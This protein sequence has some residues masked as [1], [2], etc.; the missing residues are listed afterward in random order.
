VQI[1]I[2]NQTYFPLTHEHMINLKVGTCTMINLKKTIIKDLPSP[3]SSCQSADAMGSRFYNEFIENNKSYTQK[4]CM[5]FCKQKKMI[6]NCGCYSYY[7]P[8][9]GDSKPCLD[10]NQISCSH[11]YMRVKTVNTG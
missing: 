5:Q 6:D 9:I 2:D 8:K 10:S 3:Y 4:A 1:S 7:Y 11:K